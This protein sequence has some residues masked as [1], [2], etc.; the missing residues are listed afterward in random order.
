MR[1][2]GWLKYSLIH[3]SDYGEHTLELETAQPGLR[4]Y[5]FT[6]G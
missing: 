5:T 1:Y 6:F 2:D 3:G 4:A